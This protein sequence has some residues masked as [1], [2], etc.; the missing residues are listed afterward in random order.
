M[1]VQGAKIIVCLFVTI[2]TPIIGGCAYRPGIAPGDDGR[3]TGGSFFIPADNRYRQRVLLHSSVAKYERLYNRLLAALEQRGVRV[4]SSGKAR[5]QLHIHAVH[6]GERAVT[7]GRDAKVR[8]MM[9][10]MSL[11]Y[12]W[13]TNRSTNRSMGRSKNRRHDRNKARVRE[14]VQNRGQS[15][16]KSRSGGKPQKFGPYT[17]SVEDI[18]RYDNRNHLLNKSERRRIRENLEDELIR[19]LMR[20]LSV[21]DG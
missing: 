18:Y 21:D 11:R 9:L 1:S 13:S 12:S 6:A 7:R 19:R 5:T 17:I 16:V 3:V 10:T 20:R 2:T 15:R 8:D 14:Q 4:V